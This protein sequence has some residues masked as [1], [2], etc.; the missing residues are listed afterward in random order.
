MVRAWLLLLDLGQHMWVRPATYR[1][2]GGELVEPDA[3]LSTTGRLWLVVSERS[4]Q[5]WE[6]FL[7]QVQEQRRLEGTWEWEGLVLY[8]YG[9]LE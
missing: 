9:A 6:G 5:P 8:R 3:A 4:R 2:V 1:I 7:V